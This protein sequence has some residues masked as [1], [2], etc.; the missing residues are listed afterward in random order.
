MEKV[1]T[2]I[3]WKCKVC[4][5]VYDPDKGVAVKN[6]PP[7][8]LFEDL[9]DDFRCPVCKYTRSHFYRLKGRN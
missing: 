3:K 9:P 6:I 7:K 1:G 4:G 2:G 5:F 8:I